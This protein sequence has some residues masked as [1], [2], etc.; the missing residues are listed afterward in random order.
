MLPRISDELSTLCFPKKICAHHVGLRVV[1][2]EVGL[3]VVV[4]VCK[5]CAIVL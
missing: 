5:D 4:L 1:C 3:G 2:M